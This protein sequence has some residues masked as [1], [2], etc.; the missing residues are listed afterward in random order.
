M[1]RNKFLYTPEFVL[2]ARAKALSDEEIIEEVYQYA[3]ILPSHFPINMWDIAASLHFE[4]YEADFKDETVTGIMFDYDK[5]KKLSPEISSKRAV[6]LDRNDERKIKSF[7]LAHEMSHFLLHVT[8]EKRYFKRYHV[9][10]EK[11]IDGLTEEQR[12][13][14]FQEDAADEL[15]AKMLMPKETFLHVVDSSPNRNNKEKLTNELSDAFQVGIKAIQRRFL[16][17]NVEF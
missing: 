9:T 4:V 11:N 13:I 15:A 16:E 17:L 6:V 1:D 2:K 12:F 14:K 7:T 3:N 10:K 5:P 8:D